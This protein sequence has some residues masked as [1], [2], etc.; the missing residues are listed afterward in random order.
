MRFS[1]PVA[2]VC[3][4]SR[5]QGRLTSPL[6]AT[7]T[8]R[9]KLTIGPGVW[10]KRFDM[11]KQVIDLVGVETGDR[12]FQVLHR[13]AK[14]AS[15]VSRPDQHLARSHGVEATFF[16]V[17]VT[18]RYLAEIA[19]LRDALEIRSFRRVERHGCSVTMLLRIRLGEIQVTVIAE[20]RI[21]CGSRHGRNRVSRRK[22]TR[23]ILAF[24]LSHT[25]CL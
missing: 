15:A 11:R 16:F 25:N 22:E 24:F 12:S 5:P 23:R 1:W 17:N 3:E 21:N 19:G 4:S 20:C 2:R 6:C 13:G 10:R 7:S 8:Q 9:R 18:S 14:L